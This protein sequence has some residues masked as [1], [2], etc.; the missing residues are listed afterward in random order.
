[1]AKTLL[2]HTAFVMRAEIDRLLSRGLEREASLISELAALGL[3]Y[4]VQ[5][6]LEQEQQ[7]FL[8]RA[9]YERPGRIDAT[10]SSQRL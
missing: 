10:R 2:G 1:M 6:G 5:Q 9:H 3:R 7:D 4:L 8:G